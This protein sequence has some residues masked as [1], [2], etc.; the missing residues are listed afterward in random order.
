MN[1]DSDN[2]PPKLANEDVGE[3]TEEP[4]QSDVPMTPLKKTVP[5]S[6][7]QRKNKTI[8]LIRHAQSE[9]NVKVIEL[10]DGLDRI[11]R[12]KCP[13]C[14]NI[15]STLS[16]LTLTLDSAVSRLGARQIKDMH[17]I[18]R[19]DRFWNRYKV[20]AVVCS[21]L[22]R[23]KETCEG[24]LPPANEREG[25][26]LHAKI[27]DDLEEAN[28]YEHVFAATLIERIERFKRWLHDSEEETILVVGHCQYFKKMLGQKTLMRNC[29]VWQVTLECGW[30]G[31]GQGNDARTYKWGDMTLLYRTEL[32]D[33]HPLDKLLRNEEKTGQGSGDGRAE[34]DKQAGEKKAKSRVAISDMND[35]DGVDQEHD[36]DPAC[37]ICQVRSPLYEQNSS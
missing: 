29:D 11:R 5:T 21:P 10:V 34:D 30:D 14:R 7:R 13:T 4:V 22:T 9:E 31:E 28:V 17:M 25:L 19:D 33:T 24:V 2:K 20:D 6:S 8:I 26:N 1:P 12:F 15:S 37:R 3:M 36:Q 35:G 23:A 18:L 27:L 32:A 16:L